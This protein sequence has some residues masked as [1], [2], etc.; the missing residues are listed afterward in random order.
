[1]VGTSFPVTGESNLSRTL[2]KSASRMLARELADP[3]Q[4]M[5]IEEL[6]D[7]PRS[8][9]ELVEEIYGSVKGQPGYM[10]SYSKTRRALEKLSSKGY[11]SR[12]LFGAVKPY[13]LT[14]F[15]IARITRY[16]G[17]REPP[18]LLPFTDRLLH[19]VTLSLTVLLLLSVSGRIEL[20]G[21]YYTV[22]NSIFFFSL[23]LSV[24]RIFQGL[25]RVF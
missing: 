18:R 11:V 17:G 15:A 7:G 4:V 12:K 1:M 8:V 6:V 5:I 19:L 9:A 22:L 14:D 25:R 2:R 21:S 23:G 3:L 10:T 24:A 16:S 20:T 13:R